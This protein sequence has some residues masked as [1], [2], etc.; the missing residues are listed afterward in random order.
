MFMRLM[1]FNWSR[2]HTAGHVINLRSFEPSLILTTSA[3][4]RPL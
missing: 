1:H 4:H 3:A 2:D